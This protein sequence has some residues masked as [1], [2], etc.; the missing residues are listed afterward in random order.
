MKN[1]DKLLL[2]IICFSMLAVA[3]N[4]MSSATTIEKRAV[5]LEASLE[6]GN[7]T[8]ET[9]AIGEAITTTEQQP[10][11]QSKMQPSNI[12]TEEFETSNGM[13]LM[14]GTLT[15]YEAAEKTELVSIA[16]DDKILAF[17]VS[18]APY[19]TWT[20]AHID[21]VL[22]VPM[23]SAIIDTY[24][25]SYYPSGE[26]LVVKINSSYL[27][28]LQIYT[29]S[30]GVPS[31][32]IPKTSINWDYDAGRKIITLQSKNIIKDEIV[33]FWVGFSSNDG[34]IFIEDMQKIENLGYRLNNMNREK[35]NINKDVALG[36]EK[37]GSAESESDELKLK[38]ETITKEKQEIETNL[39]SSNMTVSKLENTVTGNVAVSPSI[40]IIWAI[41]AIIL[42]ILLID[43]FFFKPKKGVEK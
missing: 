5:N 35:I 26:E 22:I 15:N 7:L 37:L 17:N 9:I 14:L 6:T 18:L 20:Y 19:S 21:G 32:I 16:I 25:T 27:N 29:G 31:I 33:F 11:N 3:I 13:K 30:K 40:V 36:E 42:I 41:I 4:S 28:E 2:A 10:G 1:A 23:Q 43:V 24:V 34:A 8:A 38:T 12:M 39:T